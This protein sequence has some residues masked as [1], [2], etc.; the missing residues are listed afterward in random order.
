MLLTALAQ[1]YR[2]RGYRECVMDTLRYLAHQEHFSD[3]QQKKLQ[4]HLDIQSQSCAGPAKPHVPGYAP[5]P[6]MG[7]PAPG[8]DSSQFKPVET[9]PGRYAGESRPPMELPIPRHSMHP[10]Q[11]FGPTPQSPVRSPCPANLTLQSPFIQTPSSLLSPAKSNPSPKPRPQPFPQMKLPGSSAQGHG[12]GPLGPTPFD[13]G[14]SNGRAAHSAHG[15]YGPLSF[16]ST[17]DGG[18]NSPRPEEPAQMPMISPGFSPMEPSYPTPGGSTPRQLQHSPLESFN[19]PNTNQVAMAQLAEESSKVPPL[20]GH[21]SASQ[22]QR[23][24]H[25]TQ[26]QKQ[27]SFPSL[28]L[29]QQQQHTQQQLRVPARQQGQYQVSLSPCTQHPMQQQPQ[30]QQR[31]TAQQPHMQDSAQGIPHSAQPRKPEVKQEVSS[32]MKAPGSLLPSTNKQQQRQQHQQ[33]Q[34]QQQ[35]WS[36]PA[37]FRN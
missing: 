33:S 32:P 25:P 27:P 30:Q 10:A 24:H 20:Y 37:Q 15:P 26:A 34:P 18:T 4:Q 7:R 9:P 8:P 23:G 29:Q 19:F 12:P 5:S 35:V 22:A 21:Q 1:E 11:S 28:Q 31:R 16:G 3:E 14:L 36:T 6:Q 13:G 2:L 17:F